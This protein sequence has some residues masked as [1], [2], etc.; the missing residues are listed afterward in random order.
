MPTSYVD[1]EDIPHPVAEEIYRNIIYLRPT[2]ALAGR[3]K[4]LG[5][6]DGGNLHAQILEKVQKNAKEQF[7]AYL[8]LHS[9]P[10]RHIGTFCYLSDSDGIARLAKTLSFGYHRAVACDRVLREASSLKSAERFIN[11]SPKPFAIDNSL[12]PYV[13]MLRVAICGV[14]ES[15]LDGADLF[16][17]SIPKIACNL[18]RKKVVKDISSVPAAE[19]QI[20]VRPYRSGLEVIHVEH[21]GVDETK[22]TPGTI[23]LVFPCGVKV[24]AQVQEHQMVDAKGKPIDIMLDT[25]TFASK[26]A[27]PVW[28][29]LQ[30][31][32]DQDLTREEC[33]K[34]FESAVPEKVFINNIEYPA[35]VGYL[36]VFRPGQR[37]TEL[38]KPSD[39]ITVD[40]IAK[41][42]LN[43][44]MSVNPR[45]EEEYSALKEFRSGVIEELMESNNE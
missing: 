1:G 22:E 6:I 17:S 29:M 27:L 38:S 4:K 41:A 33:L 42:I 32:W 8:D 44:T 26:G 13:T 3:I 16:P 5:F 11:P 20:V 23:R 21:K 2:E 45:L 24:A 35:Y 39:E 18:L 40:L 37:Y 10:K 43:K 36:P 31:I 34:F 9:V 28:P 25:R 7:K 15:M 30:N 12:S 19:Q 14:S